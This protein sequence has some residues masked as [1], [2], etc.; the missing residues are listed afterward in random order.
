VTEQ[1]SNSSS[2]PA[3]PS[4]SDEQRF[5]LIASVGIMG[6]EEDCV[7]FMELM[8]ADFQVRCE[9]ANEKIMK[10]RIT[11]LPVEETIPREV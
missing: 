4:S 8:V 9:K 2:P 6:T 3:S 5:T 11:L 10:G 7:K 1:E